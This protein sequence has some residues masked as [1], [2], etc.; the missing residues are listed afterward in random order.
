MT[1]EKLTDEQIVKAFGNVELSCRVDCSNNCPYISKAFCE[2]TIKEDVLDLINRLKAEN[3]KLKYNV[4]YYKNYDEKRDTALHS[5][6]IAEAKTEA[7]N[8]A[9]KEFAE[10]LN[11]LFC[12][13]C[14]YDG[15][16]IKDVINTLL[17]EK[18]GEVNG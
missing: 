4:N 10:E 11:S 3:N 14:E 15:R 12:P 8:E 13:M 9:I 1:P 17:K 7:R 16:D 2:D 5:K 18:V 6:L